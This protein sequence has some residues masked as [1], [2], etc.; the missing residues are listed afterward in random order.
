LEEAAIGDIV[1]IVGS[2]RLFRPVDDVLVL[3]PVLLCSSVHL[4]AELVLTGRWLERVE[5][6]AVCGESR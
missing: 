4:R 3:W 2:A 5:V 6:G 1:R